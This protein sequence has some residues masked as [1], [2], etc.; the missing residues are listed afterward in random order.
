[1][2]LGS[3]NI[4]FSQVAD[5]ITNDA[6]FLEEFQWQYQGQQKCVLPGT[7]LWVKPKWSSSAGMG[8]G[9]NRE[10]HRVRGH[11][12]IPLQDRGQ[13]LQNPGKGAVDNMQ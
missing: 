6:Y 4:A 11:R 1:M 5:G 3:I 10:E 2:I 8:S 9:R 13:S 12:E 7:V